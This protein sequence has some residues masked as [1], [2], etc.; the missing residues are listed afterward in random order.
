M[1]NS[2]TDIQV[3]SKKRWMEFECD[4]EL[5]LSSLQSI[6]YKKP[7]WE[8]QIAPLH[9]AN[10]KFQFHRLPLS[11]KAVPSCMSPNMCIHMHHDEPYHITRRISKMDWQFKV[12]RGFCSTG[13]HRN[14]DPLK[15]IQIWHSKFEHKSIKL[16]HWKQRSFIFVFYRSE[17]R[18]KGMQLSLSKRWKCFQIPLQMEKFVL[19]SKTYMDNAG[20]AL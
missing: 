14:H 3:L 20:Y 10:A 15:D 8:F 16:Y 1:I 19:W 12:S 9:T 4:G 18:D 6:F 7:L 13:F 11:H 5:E 17:I 2:G